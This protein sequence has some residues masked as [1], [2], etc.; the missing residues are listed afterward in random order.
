MPAQE[1]SYEHKSEDLNSSDFQ[2]SYSLSLS[3]PVTTVELPPTF[4][5]SAEDQK[6]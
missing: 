2:C 3:L 5:C 4:Q 1:V 6:Q